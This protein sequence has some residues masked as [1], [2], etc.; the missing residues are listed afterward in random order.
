MWFTEL[1]DKIHARMAAF[2]MVGVVN[3][4]VGVS[5][6]AIAHY[7][8]AN[9]IM[10]NVFGYGAGLLVSFTLNSRI[11]FR[12][13]KVNLYTVIR[14]LVAFLVAF[15]VNIAVVLVATRVLGQHGLLV[16]LVGVPVF[17]IAFYILCEYWVFRSSRANSPKQIS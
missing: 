12:K 4:I 3:T 15:L 10:A 16:A 17:T 6:I 8:G 7:L 2:S 9:P 13:R 11:T 1:P 14:F 5:V